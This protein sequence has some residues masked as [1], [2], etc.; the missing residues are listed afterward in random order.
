MRTIQQKHKA[1]S[2]P[3]A[4]LT[5]YRAMPTHSID[6]L[7]P[8]LFLNHHGPQIYKP[9]NNGLP[10]GP[11]PHRGFETLTF[12]L[13]GDIVHWD[14]SGSKSKIKA[15]GIQWMTAGSGLIHSEISS[16]EFKKNGGE[17]EVI[18]LWL[19]LP[20]QHKMTPPKYYGLPEEEL[21]HF[22]LDEGKVK[23]H[24]ISGKWEEHSGPVPSLTHLTMSQ[25]DLENGGAFSVSVP[26]TDNILFYVI[27]GKL[28]VNGKTVGTHEL[29]E[30]GHDGEQISVKALEDAQIIF[31][32]GTPFNEPIVAQGPFVMNTER[33]IM[34]A[35]QDFRSGKMG[36]WKQ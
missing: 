34:E 8:F 10:F 6:H 13:K 7:D 2:A 16:E 3:I 35:Y 14:S 24:L 4:D 9:N 5:T 15:G 36:T 31:G 26:E 19:N 20:S 11:H 28:E 18:Q 29:L 25:T 27:N 12:V 30:F 1:V 23:V 21:T 32:Y 17:V 22:D 33:E